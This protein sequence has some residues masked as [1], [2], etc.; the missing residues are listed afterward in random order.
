MLETE[1]ELDALQELL[2]RSRSRATGHLRSIIDDERALS[3][4]D[5]A[6]LMQNMKVLSLARSPPGASPGSAPWTGTF[7]TEPGPG[8]QTALRPR[9]GI[10]RRGPP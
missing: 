6:G 9:H 1:A 3:A 8:A 4:R 5:I 10:S 7:C 2:E